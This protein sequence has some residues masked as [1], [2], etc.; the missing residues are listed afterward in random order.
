MSM[1]Q[2]GVEI[3]L[4][5]TADSRASWTDTMKHIALEGRCFVL[6]C[7]QYFTKSM[8]P[9]K[10]LPLVKDEPEKMCE[11]GSLIVSPMGELIVE[12]L[13]GSTGALVAE[14]DLNEVQKS[15]LDFDVVGH[16][17]RKDIFSYTAANQPEMLNEK[18][19]EL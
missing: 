3:Y 18:D 16:Y 19:I 8:Y 10:F 13:F 2:K 15:K 1:Y 14:L 17:A 9:E 11:G 5:P 7:N 4:A 12:P 6:G